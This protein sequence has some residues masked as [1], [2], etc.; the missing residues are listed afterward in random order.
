MKEDADGSRTHEI[1]GRRIYVHERS[2]NFAAQQ[3]EQA[4]RLILQ[5][6][7]FTVAAKI[8]HHHLEGAVDLG[9]I[10][11]ETSAQ[12]IDRLTTLSGPRLTAALRRVG[13]RPS[14]SRKFGGFY[15]LLDPPEEIVASCAEA[16]YFTFAT[17]IR[18]AE[19]MYAEKGSMRAERSAIRAGGGP[20]DVTWVNG[21]NL[22]L[23]QLDMPIGE[24]TAICH[25]RARSQKEVSAQTLALVRAEMV[26]AVLA[27]IVD[28]TNGEQ[29]WS[30]PAES[31]L[32]DQML[33]SCAAALAKGIFR[34]E[35]MRSR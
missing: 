31:M 9:L 5:A 4:A 17:G 6:L 28:A 12:L 20:S 13:Y 8:V 11:A 27:S 29:S 19:R 30:G 1:D 3:S 23:I 15:P 33:S 34:P 18:A 10:S 22:A 16:G 25:I 14:E 35:S 7:G 21:R 26:T 2:F 24:C 32:R